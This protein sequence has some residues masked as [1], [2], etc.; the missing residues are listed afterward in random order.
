M[1][2]RALTLL[3][4]VAGGALLGALA[5]RAFLRRGGGADARESAHA[6]GEEP[7]QPPDS[8]E[9][10]A[11]Q[12]SRTASFFGAEAHARIEG[13]RVVVVGV[14]GVGSHA[15][16]ALC[17][18]GVRSLRVIDFDN[19]TLSSLNR[20]ATA[21][22]RDVGTPKVNALRRAL[23]RVAP[24]CRVEAVQELLAAG[25]VEELLLPPGARRPDFVLDCIDD[26]DTKAALLV[27][28]R[29][30][31][32]RVLSSLGAGGKADPTRVLIG[33]LSLVR[34]DPLGTAIR[35]HLR[36]LG[37]LPKRTE[38]G[39]EL[40]R[41]L[42]K[43]A[44]AVARTAD[45]ASLSTCE[46]EAADRVEGEGAGE[47][48]AE[49]TVLLSGIPCVYSSEPARVKLLPLAIEPGSGDSP[50]DFG[51]L[52][53]FRTRVLPVLGV[54]PAIFGQA[55]ASHVL[56]ALA[57]GEH[58][59][60]PQQAIPLSLSSVK[61][62]QSAGSVYDQRNY[63]ASQP[64]WSGVTGGLSLEEVDFVVS[65]LWHQRSPLSGLRTNTRGVQMILCRWRPWAGSRP[66]NTVLL[67]QSEAHS[68][69]ASTTCPNL[70]GLIA[71]A[72]ADLEAAFREAATA[73]AGADAF[74]RI[75]RRLRWARSQGWE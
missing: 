22:R 3:G 17:R 14:G 18:S 67:Q 4:G 63:P 50:A 10:L 75:E 52:P 71:N 53:N 33:D 1:Q 42:K 55:M 64:G 59:L 58:V 20:H 36:R 37:E 56:C 68:L 30:R 24:S 35:Q 40:V 39:R 32:L 47:G 38:D 41:A 13:A 46:S 70:L 8:P 34:R 69:L 27:F 65:E 15:A 48:E 26:R 51:A 19:V 25:N 43:K 57:G 7:P 28:C 9:L 49:A 73:V 6:P 31:G 60:E 72:S 21:V 5:Y 62:M 11:E 66:S 45:G 2:L 74:E 54:M 16:A 23:A 12:L 61:K 44:A 29:V